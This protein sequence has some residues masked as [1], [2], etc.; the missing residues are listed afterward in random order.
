MIVH[1]MMIEM[2]NYDYDYYEF[3]VPLRSKSQFTFLECQYEFKRI[4]KGFAKEQVIYVKYFTDN[5]NRDEAIKK[6]KYSVSILEYIFLI[7]FNVQG[8]SQ[9]E[10]PNNINNVNSVNKLL[11]LRELE[12]IITKLKKSKDKFD[13]A[14]KVFNRGFRYSLNPDFSEEA[15]LN[16]FKVVESISKDFFKIKENN[17]IFKVKTDDLS[18]YLEK[19]YREKF[20]IRLSD[21]KLNDL[22]G[23]I[24]E[25][26]MDSVRRDIFNKISFFCNSHNIRVDYNVLGRAI[27]LRNKI[28]HGVDINMY[29]YNDEYVCI[30]HLSKDMIAK[31]F[32]NKTYRQISVKGRVIVDPPD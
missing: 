21:N 16:F 10:I 14:I 22:S 24:K 3:I 5:P 30:F 8:Y 23:Q 6:M 2:L 13:N 4:D 1:C 18:Q 15:Y 25:Q 29:D 17:G 7:P 9:K 27:K 31:M 32:F 26:L 19:F 12:V 11:F 28:A 20:N